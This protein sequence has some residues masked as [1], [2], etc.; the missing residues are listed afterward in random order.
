VLPYP[1][2]ALTSN[3]SNADRAMRRSR[4]RTCGHTHLHDYMRCPSI[5]RGAYLRWN[6]G[7]DKPLQSG[8]YDPPTLSSATALHLNSLFDGFRCPSRAACVEGAC[9]KILQRK[10]SM[11]HRSPVEDQSTALRALEMHHRFTPRM[12]DCDRAVHCVCRGDEA[13]RR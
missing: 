1:S 4:A 8:S 3:G 12:S 7:D 5:C 2:D 6:H 10:S 9:G 11:P 13:L